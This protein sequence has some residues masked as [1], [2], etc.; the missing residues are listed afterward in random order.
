[1]FLFLLIVLGTTLA[2]YYLVQQYRTRALESADE[3]PAEETRDRG[4]E[5]P[6]AA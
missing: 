2:A 5:L 1:M 6:R 4:A 3:Q